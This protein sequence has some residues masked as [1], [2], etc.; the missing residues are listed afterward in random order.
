M[1]DVSSKVIGALQA[2]QGLTSR[3]AFN[4]GEDKCR[5]TVTTW[6][7]TSGGAASLAISHRRR[8][9]RA[10]RPDGGGDY[11]DLWH[12]KSQLIAP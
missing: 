8:P 6:K 10:G 12:L 4:R 5:D 9:C 1:R 11:A 7:E 2:R 3:V